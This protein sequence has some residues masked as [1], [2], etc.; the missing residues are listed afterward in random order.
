MQ[1]SLI[2]WKRTRDVRRF[3]YLK[4]EASPQPLSEGEEL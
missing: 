2:K 4:E 1:K 3:N